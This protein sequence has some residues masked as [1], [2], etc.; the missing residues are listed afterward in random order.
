M[1]ADL[2]GTVYR[3]TYNGDRVLQELDDNRVE[4]ARY[5]TES[6]SYYQPWLYMKRSD[7][8]H[9]YPMYDGTGNTRKLV[10][11][12]GGGPAGLARPH[13]CRSGTNG[14]PVMRLTMA[15]NTSFSRSPAMNPIASGTVLR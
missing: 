6:G 5:I 11:S 10:D 1:R 8:V 12:A 7:R 9:M 4:L 13:H 15:Q 3:Y 14:L 2:N